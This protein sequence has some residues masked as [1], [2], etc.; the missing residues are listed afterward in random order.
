MRPITKFVIMTIIIS[1]LLLIAG[2]AN[3]RG[4]A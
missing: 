2:I 1:T 3:T 4:L